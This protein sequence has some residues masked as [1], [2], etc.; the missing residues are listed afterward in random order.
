M[1]VDSMTESDIYITLKKEYD[2]S[3]APYIRKREYK[4]AKDII[5]KC[6]KGDKYIKLPWEEVQSKNLIKYRIRPEG[7][8]KEFAPKIV[9]EFN[10]KGKTCFAFYG[11]KKALN[12]FQDHCLDRYAERVLK[13]EIKTRDVFYKHVMPKLGYAYRTVLPSP[14]HQYSKYIAIGDALFLGD[15]NPDYPD[16]DDWFNTC[17]SLNETGPSQTKLFQTLKNVQ[18]DIN[19][20]GF[21]PF[22]PSEVKGD[23]D[24]QGMF[25]RI[26]KTTETIQALVRLTKNVYLID[27]LCLMSDFPFVSVFQDSF[28][29]RKILAKAILEIFSID[30]TKLTP[31][32]N[33]GIAIRG[34]LDFKGDKF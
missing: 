14:T 8:R 3:I 18:E 15:F 6:P 2:I 26:P 20:I 29:Y 22:D 4:Y 30:Y 17:I 31:Y 23:C 12:V 33:D 21:N 16:N 7:S 28:N 24:I 25:N 11:D 13:K 5:S 27:K 19:I 1:I 9:A 34:E 32:G 10:W